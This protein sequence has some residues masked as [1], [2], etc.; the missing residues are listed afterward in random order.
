MIRIECTACKKDIEDVTSIV[1]IIDED[2]FTH[3]YCNA[4]GP[5]IRQR[6]EGRYKD[7]DGK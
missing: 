2:G 7:I 4:C 1:N 5:E 3:T 6:L